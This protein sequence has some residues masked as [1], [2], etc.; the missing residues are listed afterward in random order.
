M[1]LVYRPNRK[2]Q[3]VTCRW[4]RWMMFIVET[5]RGGEGGGIKVGVVKSSNPPF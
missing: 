3:I 5:T 2:L 1:R 4:L